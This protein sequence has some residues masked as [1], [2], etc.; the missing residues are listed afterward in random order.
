[1][2]KA[3][4]ETLHREVAIK[5]LTPTLAKA[6]LLERFR[7]EATALAKLN[8]PAIATIYEL[9]QSDDNL[10]MV[11]ELVRGDTLEMLAA[12]EGPLDPSRAV[13][14]VDQILSALEHAHRAG[15]VHCDIKPANV[16][17]TD[18][19]AVKIMDFGIAHVCGDDLKEVAGG[20][21]GTPGYMSP[22]QALGQELDARADLYA[23][24]V[25]LY[26]LLTGA[27]PFSAGTT[28]QI[29]RQQIS[30][31]PAPLRVHQDGL[32]VWCELIVG[33]ALA[34]SPAARFQT[35]EEFRA[36]LTRA[37]RPAA[38]ERTDKISPKDVAHLP[39]ERWA[40][41]VTAGAARLG[42]A[43]GLTGAA[44]TPR[45]RYLAGAGV[46]AALV[47]VSI[48]AL[49][50][51]ARWRTA[52]GPAAT[53]PIA[54]PTDVL[55]VPAAPTVSAPATQ[56]APEPPAPASPAPATASVPARATR[57][58]PSLA[59]PSVAPA[60]AASRAVNRE[61]TA[62]SVSA[63][64]PPAAAPEST[65]VDRPAGGAKVFLPLAFSAKALV[66]DGD[67]RRERDVR[68]FLADGRVTVTAE[69]LPNDVVHVQAYDAIR[70]IDYSKSR[71]PFW[72]SPDGP[73]QAARAGRVLGIF[74]RRR[75]WITL[76]TNDTT[77]PLI[78]LRVENEAQVKRAIAALE[79]RTHHTAATLVEPG[80]VR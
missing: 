5:I 76:R 79:E 23:V 1:M 48:T 31:V 43:A 73:V 8:H 80:D 17:V 55:P 40:R 6:G 47:A 70:A 4:D 64:P 71:H 36:V 15:I 35:A 32:P 61:P 20:M 65:L 25:V 75:H 59:S 66:G 2:Y 78:V 34:K 41:A 42:A 52:P 28:T 68:V 16:L 67:R 29:L 18:S 26:R 14:F 39:S 72:R 11:M 10:V 54:A 60:A 24:G 45:K 50:Y 33:R 53:S 46:L 74:P 27:L 44:G 37:T 12:R 63:G 77:N 58:N 9:V 56:T 7:I 49:G 30:D 19:G 3:V 62:A 21:T 22:E 38:V 13:H 51:G 57:E 69:A